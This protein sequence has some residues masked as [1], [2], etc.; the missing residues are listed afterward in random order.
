MKD[1]FAEII[2][3]LYWTEIDASGKYDDLIEKWKPKDV[4]VRET[5]YPTRM[6][7]QCEPAEVES[8]PSHNW[9]PGNKGPREELEE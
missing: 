4:Y 1:R 2:T 9:A 3:E 8:H 5:N 7:V 6:I